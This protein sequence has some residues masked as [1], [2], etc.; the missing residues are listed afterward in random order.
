MPRPGKAVRC[1]STKVQLC[2]L[3]AVAHDGVEA[4][5]RHA[6]LARLGLAQD[7]VRQ[8]VHA[9]LAV[10]ADRLAVLQH[11]PSADSRSG[12]RG[13]TPTTGTC[14]MLCS[15]AVDRLDA[16]LEHVEL[17]R[18]PRRSRARGRTS[19]RGCAASSVSAS[20]ALATS[21]AKPTSLPPIDSSS[22]S[23]LRALLGVALL[24]HEAALELGH[25]AVHVVG[26]GQVVV[27]RL[28]AARTAPRPA[29]E[30]CDSSGGFG[31]HSWPL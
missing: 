18:R 27:A 17:A 21:R 6:A 16:V 20:T 25:P 5:G 4:L 3:G 31:T 30:I 22:R 8:H 11:A 23:I 13:R 24:E 26:L 14:R 2:W 9:G 1:A 7:E 19:R 15:G 10:R 29:A 28:P 12:P